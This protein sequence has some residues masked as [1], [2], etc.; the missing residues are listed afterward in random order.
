MRLVQPLRGSLGELELTGRSRQHV[1][2]ASDIGCTLQRDALSAFLALREAA[3]A[4]GFDLRA[5]S[6][7]RDF[8]RQ[9][10]IW[11]SKFRGER[12]ILDRS[13]NQLD[14]ATLSLAERVDAI[15]LWSALPGASRHHWGTDFDVFDAAAMPERSRL[16]LVPEE[17]EIGGPFAPLTSWLDTHMH[18]FGFF[19]PYVAPVRGGEPSGVSPEPWHLSYA[20]LATECLNALTPEILSRAIASSSM[21]GR[22]VVLARIEELH[23]RF[24]ADVAPASA[25]S[26]AVKLGDHRRMV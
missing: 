24:V 11:N 16:R 26:L 7:F 9:L 13:G 18:Q 15:L 12:P 19:R 21:D 20:P 1:V 4:A 22:E 14:A 2:E 5:A 25:A 23:H 17:Y 6:S 8:D 10:T 3:Q